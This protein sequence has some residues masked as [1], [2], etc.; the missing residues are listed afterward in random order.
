M[1]FPFLD[2][3]I[4]LNFLV[5]IIFIEVITLLIFEYILLLWQVTSDS[6]FWSQIINDRLPWY[7]TGNRVLKIKR[8]ITSTDLYN[9]LSP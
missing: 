2:T 3:F 4:Y 9:C 7:V 8:G 1:A 6:K 5:R